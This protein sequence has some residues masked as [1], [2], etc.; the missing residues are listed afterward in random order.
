MSWIAAE[1]GVP[2]P[3]ADDV[4]RFAG[5]VVGLRA[6][7]RTLWRWLRRDPVPGLVLVS[8]ILVIGLLAFLVGWTGWSGLAGGLTLVGTVAAAA[9]R[10]RATVTRIRKVA[11]KLDT[12]DERAGVLSRRL[13]ELDREAERLE[14][15]VADLAPVRLPLSGRDTTTGVVAKANL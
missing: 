1:L 5:E 8:G 12:P 4:R 10:V 6:E 11:D 15:A 7:T 2:E 14:R 9:A 3:T 13:A